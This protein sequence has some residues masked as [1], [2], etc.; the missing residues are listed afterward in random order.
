MQK[1]FKNLNKKA[2]GKTKNKF[3]SKN[4]LKQKYKIY[5]FPREG[6]TNLKQKLRR[7]LGIPSSLG[8]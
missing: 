2:K 4:I 6:A 5:P 7:S 8:D 3:K 1:A